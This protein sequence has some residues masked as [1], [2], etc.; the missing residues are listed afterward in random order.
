M[1]PAE[2]RAVGI[3][4]TVSIGDPVSIGGAVDL[5]RTGQR[6]PVGGANGAVFS[7]TERVARTVRLPELSRGA[8]C[9]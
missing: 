1:Q 3:G 7:C 6:Q 2:R 4:G 8:R 5:G 9:V